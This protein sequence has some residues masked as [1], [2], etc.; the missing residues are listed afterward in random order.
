MKK[1]IKQVRKTKLISD[2][3]GKNIPKQSNSNDNNSISNNKN[4]NSY[5]RER[6]QKEK[7]RHR[8]SVR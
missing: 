3:D 1:E 6:E 2:K 5:E 8:K 7:C 4:N